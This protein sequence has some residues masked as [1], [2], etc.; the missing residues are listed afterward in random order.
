[1]ERKD[2]KEYCLNFLRYLT[3][4]KN[5]SD[6]TIL[7]YNNDLNIFINFLHKKNI[8]D[9]NEID[10]NVIRL[11]MLFLKEKKLSNRTL[12][13]YYSSLNSF[14]K[15]LL[16]HEIIN[17]NPLELIDYPKY[18]KRIP[19]YIYESNIN[20]LLN[21][22][23]ADKIELE[24]RNKAIVYLLLD[25]GLRLSE[26]VNIK[27]SDIDFIDRSIK[28]FGKGSKDRYV[29][30]TSKTLEKINNWMN[31]WK[32]IADCEYLF[33]NYKGEKITPRSVEK[34]IKKLGELN[35]LN[36]HPHMLRHTFA[37]ELLN[38]GA[39]IRLIQEL[40]GHESLDTTQI[41]THISNSRIKEV[42]DYSHKTK[43]V[44]N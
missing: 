3:V 1:M 43:K 5:Y 17:Q 42:Y 15:Y 32:N 26:L 27:V 40:L 2:I 28:V 33:V 23:T 38:K 14:F 24:A 25:S 4:E 8:N 12:G 29:F 44:K 11:F 9:L 13:R 19:E 7:S 21:T 37:T 39:D 41:Y 6:K 35:G 20:D 34:I 31:Y 30:F 16:E 10:K 18:K 22:Q 36:L